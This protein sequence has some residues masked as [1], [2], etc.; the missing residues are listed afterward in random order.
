MNVT[1]IFEQFRKS[2]D[3]QSAAILTLAS[4]LA[5]DRQEETPL[6]VKEAAKRLAVSTDTIYELCE[7]GKLPHQRI[8]KGRGTIRIRPADLVDLD[9]APKILPLRALIR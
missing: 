3:D 5:G 9:G 1:S 4:V 2:T 7:S 6:T 8:G